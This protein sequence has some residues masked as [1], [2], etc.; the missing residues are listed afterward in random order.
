VPAAGGG[1][2]ALRALEL[3]GVA[4][5][6]KTTLARELTKHSARLTGGVPFPRLAHLRPGLAHAA[7]L[8]PAW[9]R[10]GGRW[11]DEKELRSMNYVTGWAD[12][13][14]RRRPGDTV[15]LFDHG[16]L[17]RIARL[18]AF[19]PPL[20]ESA[21]FQAWADAALR[22][23]APLLGGVVWLD[24]PDDLLVA[25]IEARGERHRMQGEP[26]SDTLRFLARYR[27]AYER[28]LAEFEA[29]GGPPVLRI[30]TRA[31]PAA[32]IAERLLAQLAL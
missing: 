11:L 4:A 31:E 17:F 2:R 29:A 14:E 12:R 22:R 16:P 25:R 26:L 1:A 19:G 21:R 18:R 32:L 28:L 3:V 5:S 9:W 23:W 24:A 27:A 15:V 30:D 13:V 6:G 8:L 10:A 20:V 7:R